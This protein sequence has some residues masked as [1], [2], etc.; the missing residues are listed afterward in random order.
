MIAVDSDPARRHTGRREQSLYL[1]ERF[2]GRPGVRRIDRQIGIDGAG[3][4][5][6]PY[7]RQPDH[8]GALRS[9]KAAAG[10]A[11]KDHDGA[12]GFL[13][14]DRMTCAIIVRDARR[15]HR[16]LG[17]GAGPQHDGKANKR[18]RHAVGAIASDG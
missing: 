1:P 4:L 14:H 11:D 2:R 17:M 3:P 13:D 12:I 18:S 7:P 5:L 10:V 6:Q 8:V 15:R 9:G 16:L